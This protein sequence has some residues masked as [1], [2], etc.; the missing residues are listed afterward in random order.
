MGQQGY[1]SGIWKGSVK[2]YGVSLTKA[3]KPQ[4]FVVF[5]VEFIDHENQTYTKPMTWYG[6]LNEGKA[7]EITI[8]ALVNLGFRGVDP[9][10]MA[11]GP[12]SG[13]IDLGR[14]A[15]LTVD[16]QEV[17]NEATGATRTVHKIAWVNAPGGGVGNIKRLD[18]Q[19]AKA[20]M[21]TMNLTASVSNVKKEMGVKDDIGF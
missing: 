14:E 13:P 19:A 12:E 10:A 18:P 20:K 7:R 1:I 3:E 21:A 6:S 8:K 5:D 9:S 4:I 15:Q 16:E 17:V 11:N 2:D